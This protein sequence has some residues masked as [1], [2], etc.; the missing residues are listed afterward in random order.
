MQVT[1]HKRGIRNG[2]KAL[3][4]V[5]VIVCCKASG[6]MKLPHFFCCIGIRGNTD[7]R[8]GLTN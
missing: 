6:R 1:P 7:K 3:K 5:L 8:N 2:P 4:P